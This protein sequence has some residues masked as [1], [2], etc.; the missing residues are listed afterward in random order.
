M[1]LEQ[2]QCEISWLSIQFRFFNLTEIY[3]LM[4]SL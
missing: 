1:I 4:L 2:S 3:T